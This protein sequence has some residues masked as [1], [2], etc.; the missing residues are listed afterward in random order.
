[1][2]APFPCWVAFNADDYPVAFANGDYVSKVEFERDL[3]ADGSSAVRI[4]LVT[5]VAE[6][7]RLL[8]IHAGP[9][10]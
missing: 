8:D 1:M 4:E 3:R 10:K 5:D 6:R 2:S 9:R 7:N